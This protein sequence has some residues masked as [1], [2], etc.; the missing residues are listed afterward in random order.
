LQLIESMSKLDELLLLARHNRFIALIGLGRENCQFLK[1]LI[2]VVNFPKEQILLADQKPLAQAAAETLDCLQNYGFSDWQCVFG[3]DYLSVL[4]KPNLALVFKSPGIWSLKPEFQE[5]RK[6]YGNDRIL[7]SLVFFLEKY[8]PQIV[9]I[10]GT[11]GKSTTANLTT[12]LINSVSDLKAVYCGNSV[13]L[14]PYVYWL[15]LDQ[16]VDPRQLFVL[17]LSSFQL[18]DLGYSR[19]SPKYALIT[20]YYIDHLDQ[21]KDTQE[22]WASKDNLFLFQE[23]EDFCLVGPSVLQN[24]LHPELIANKVLTSAEVAI[25]KQTFTSPLIGEHNWLN[26]AL[27]LKVTEFITDK[28]VLAEKELYQQAIISYPKLPHRLELVRTV[29]LDNLTVN[30]FDDG[31]ATDPDAVVAAIRSF[32]RPGEYLW[33]QLCGKD[34][35]T[36]VENLFLAILEVQQNLSLFRVDF[37]G[38]IGLKVQNLF[39]QTLGLE[40]TQQIQPFRQTVKQSFVNLQKIQQDFWTWFRVQQQALNPNQLVNLNVKVVLNIVL[41]PGGSSFDEFNNQQERAE[42]WVKKVQELQ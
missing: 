10:T 41:S 21:H 5:F 36:P 33:L 9:G 30:F 32:N 4:Q 35:G 39:N 16:P 17:E 2:E 25:Y 40:T 7:S 26:L 1:W 28:Q 34:K 31:Y 6:L 29:Q 19:I 42:W 14:S 22:Y 20:N 15:T 12:H 23:P 13:N 38:E 3:Q 8:R 24:S 11:K 37:C 27:S 18:E